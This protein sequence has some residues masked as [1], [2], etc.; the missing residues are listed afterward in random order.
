MVG[1]KLRSGPLIGLG[2][3]FLAASLGCV[4]G[5]HSCPD[6]YRCERSLED[7]RASAGWYDVKAEEAVQDVI[8]PEDLFS[9]AK[10]ARA[11]R[12][13]SVPVQRKSI[14][15][16]TG[17]GCYGAYSAGVLC[18]WSETGAR[19]TFD[20]V[21][22]TSTGAL[23]GCFAFLGSQYDADLR[24]AYT[25][26][27]N[28]DLYRMRK[29]PFNLISDS[30]ADNTAM[31][32]LIENSITDERVKAVGQEYHKGRRFY[33]GTSDLDARR[34]VVWDI[35]AIAA[36]DNPGDR[37]LIR[38]ILL[39]S[40][41]IPGFFPPVTIPVVVD[42]VRRCERHVDGVTS[43][44]M[45]FAPPWVPPAERATLP[46]G[47]LYDSDMYILVAGKLYADPSPVKDRTFSIISQAVS[48]LL[49]DQ[50]RSDLHR[51][52]LLSILTGMNYYE[53]HIPQEMQVPKSATEF[54]PVEMTRMFEAGA[55]WAKCDRKWRETPPGYEPG[56]GPRYRSGAVLMD[57]G[58][59]G[60]AMP[61][62]PEGAPL[63]PAPPIK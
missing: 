47:W 37:E 27:R 28:E 33:V 12:K 17:G 62:G 5:G 50:T 21:T 26:T 57:V 48:T 58:R 8:R 46:A 23:L 14:L 30:L 2:L 59:R 39:A 22:G 43:S 56:E 54:D 36:R 13:P 3:V 34:A 10:Q 52:F 7:L 44:S 40:A 4:G 49:Y 60:P 9:F 32:D 53:S 42:G 19:P 1:K 38:K 16:V 20:V 15:I 55:A 29:F 6:T 45:Y 35:T 11:A 61:S 41:S 18:G 25:C 31:A 51:M 24:R 63:A